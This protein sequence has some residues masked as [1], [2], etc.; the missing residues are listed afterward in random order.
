MKERERQ[1]AGDETFG[2]PKDARFSA[3]RSDPGN[4]VIPG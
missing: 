4:H 1:L 2:A 3:G